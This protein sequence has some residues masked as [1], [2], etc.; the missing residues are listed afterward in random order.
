MEN[1]SQ[2]IQTIH[3]GFIQ[4]MHTLRAY[5]KESKELLE[6]SHKQK[7]ELVQKLSRIHQGEEVPPEP[8]A[9][10]KIELDMDE[11]SALV[12]AMNQYGRLSDKYPNM[13][14]DMGFI[15]LVA[16]FDAYLLDV[17]CAVLTDRPETL[18]SSKKQLSYDKIIDLQ[19][20]S[21]LIPYLAQREMDEV[22][23]KSIVE[24]AEYYESKFNIKIADSGVTLDDL[25][26]I[27]AARNLLVHNN[28][29]VNP[30]YLD[31]VRNSKY[32]SGERIATDLDYWNNCYEKLKQV[33][34]FIRDA[35]L[36]K[37]Q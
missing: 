22:G 18:K 6:T 1:L 12:E 19:A 27:R 23:Y 26:E 25:T 13:L 9:T 14:L 3:Y 21:V 2:T 28:G 35:I 10:I 15:Y 16:L 29:I 36:S 17:F 24:Q 7:A 31:V 32:K 8:D 37:F 11:I 20:S 5:V 4:S 30:I 34:E 33:A